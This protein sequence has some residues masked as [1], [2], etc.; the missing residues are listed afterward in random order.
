MGNLTGVCGWEGS[1]PRR[2]LTLASGAHT[3]GWGL[4]QSQ[5]N[6]QFHTDGRVQLELQADGFGDA[7]GAYAVHGGGGGAGAG[8]GTG[9]PRA[10]IPAIQIAERPCWNLTWT[11]KAV[12]WG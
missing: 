11:Q 4:P 10:P 1:I 5:G 3:L 9:I 6:C 12:R 7:N 2:N 8:V